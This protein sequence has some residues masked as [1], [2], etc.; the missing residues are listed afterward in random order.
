MAKAPTATPLPST[1]AEVFSDFLKK[2]EA[3]EKLD[4]KLV[5]RI[6]QTLNDQ[7]FDADSLRAAL[8]DPVDPIE[9]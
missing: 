4:K 8:F 3:D 7:K 5:E 6:K 2:L 1:V 9:T